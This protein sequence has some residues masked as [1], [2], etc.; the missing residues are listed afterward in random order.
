MKGLNRNNREVRLGIGIRDPRQ[1]HPGADRI[2]VTRHQHGVHTCR[3]QHLLQRLLNLVGLRSAAVPPAS[4]A[5][6]LRSGSRS[7]P[8]GSAGLPRSTIPAPAA[9]PASRFGFIRIQVESSISDRSSASASA[10]YEKRERR[11]RHHR[12]TA[13]YHAA[14][15]AAAG[16][17]HHVPVVSVV[18]RSPRRSLRFRPAPAAFDLVEQQDVGIEQAEDLRYSA[19]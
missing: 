4:P 17:D 18:P 14:L 12:M 16:A 13:D 9:I 3:L 1:R 10:E 7:E 15:T 8:R 11:H 19:A 6:R 5:C 2:E